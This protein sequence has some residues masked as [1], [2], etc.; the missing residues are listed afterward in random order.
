MDEQVEKIIEDSRDRG[1]ELLKKEIEFVCSCENIKSGKTKDRL[2]NITELYGNNKYS[3]VLRLIINT[4]MENHLKN[5]KI[6]KVDNEAFRSIC[7]KELNDN[8]Y[9]LKRNSENYGVVTYVSKVIGHINNK[10]KYNYRKGDT[11]SEIYRGAY[12][13]G[14]YIISKWILSGSLQGYDE[15]YSANLISDIKDVVYSNRNK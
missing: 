8:M 6:M 1:F 5:S 9:K 14:L 11:R 10:I 12:I 2:L 4:E 15:W 3:N 7:E 13:A